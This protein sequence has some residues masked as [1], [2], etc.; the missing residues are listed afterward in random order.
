MVA[1]YGDTKMLLRKDQLEESLREEKKLIENG[2]LKEDSPLDLSE[3]FS[4][5]CE[6]CRRGDLKLCQEMITGGV[7]INARDQFD[8]SPLILVGNFHSISCSRI[9]RSC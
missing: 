5:L 3:G 2:R 6:A 8:Y 7:N 1:Q 9:E 4:K